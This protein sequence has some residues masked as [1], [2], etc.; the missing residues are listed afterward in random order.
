MFMIAKDRHYILTITMLVLTSFLLFTALGCE[1]IAEKQGLDGNFNSDSPGDEMTFSAKIKWIS[2]EGGFYGLVA[3]D[4]RRF[5]PNN[6]PPEFR[7]DGLAVWVRGKPADVATIQMWG[8]PFEIYE[9]KI[10]K[11]P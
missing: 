6:L 11:E 7:Q 3:K 1:P 10:S 2:L 8:T 9:I 5:L 4:G